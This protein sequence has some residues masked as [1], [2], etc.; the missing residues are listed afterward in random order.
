MSGRGQGM[1]A[2]Y[3]APYPARGSFFGW[4]RGGGRGWRNQYFAT[5]IPGRGRAAWGAPP[6]PYGYTMS[7]EEEIGGLKNH[8]QILQEELGSIQTRIKELEE[9]REA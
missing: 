8:A 3:G 9:T 1:C 7:R 4:R 6:F 5:G 2:E